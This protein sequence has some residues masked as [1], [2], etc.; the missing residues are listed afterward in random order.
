MGSLGPPWTYA[1][2]AQEEEGHGARKEEIRGREGD[3]TNCGIFE[4]A[5]QELALR[6]INPSKPPPI[7]ITYG[8]TASEKATMRARESG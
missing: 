6:R 8:F 5:Q 4:V 3:G 7:G 1:H 2:D